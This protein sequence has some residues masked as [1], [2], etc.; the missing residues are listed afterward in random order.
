VGPG[1]PAGFTGA[2]GAT[3]NPG[4]TGFVGPQGQRGE[5]CTA[6]LCGLLVLKLERAIV[7][8]SFTLFFN[9]RFS[10]SLE[11]RAISSFAAVID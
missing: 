1:G 6:E 5:A 3:G 8:F 7:Y 9:C 4:N 2:S 10:S 11:K